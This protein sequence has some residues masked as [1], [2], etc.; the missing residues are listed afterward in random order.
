MILWSQVEPFPICLRVI[1]FHACSQMAFSSLC[2]L[3][4]QNFKLE[5][6]C[7]PTTGEFLNPTLEF[8]TH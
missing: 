3:P 1:F 7:L 8:M 6:L 2:I 5:Y 4:Y